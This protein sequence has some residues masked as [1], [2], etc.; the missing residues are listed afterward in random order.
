MKHDSPFLFRGE[1]LDVVSFPPN[2]GF[3]RCTECIAGKDEAM[4]EELP[5]CG[6]AKPVYFVKHELTF[7]DLFNGV[8]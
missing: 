1:S 3:D 7:E 6:G 5:T 4:C 8:L 2:R